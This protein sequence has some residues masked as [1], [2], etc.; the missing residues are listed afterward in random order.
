MEERPGARTAGQ[1][2]TLLAALASACIA[3]CAIAVPASATNE[4]YKCNACE[5]TNGPNN[6]VKNNFGI[7]H[8]GK[9]ACAAIW[10]YNGGSNYTLLA[11]ECL[12]SG[13]TSKDC[14]GSEVVG[15]GEVEAEE[16]NSLLLGRQDNFSA[17]E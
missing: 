6:Y 10:R 17:C 2:A 8:S 7:N 13:K 5:E 4:Y 14:L 9:G 16:G 11:D 15:H 3:A 12:T 1:H